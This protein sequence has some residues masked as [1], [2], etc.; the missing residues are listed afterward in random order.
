MVSLR[1]E[2]EVLDRIQSQAD[3]RGVKKIPYL[4]ELIEVGLEARDNV[5]DRALF[6]AVRQT[7]T[8]SRSLPPGVMTA[9]ELMRQRQARLNKTVYRDR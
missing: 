9:A 5:E 1:L 3:E 6:R 2:E 8:P 4:A 7:A